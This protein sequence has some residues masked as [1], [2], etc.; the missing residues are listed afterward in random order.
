MNAR[1]ISAVA[2]CCSLAGFAVAIVAGAFAGGDTASVIGRAI[3]SMLV[4]YAVGTALAAV[5]SRVVV[6]HADTYQRANDEA[7]DEGRMSPRVEAQRT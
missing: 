6:E 2:P 7:H 3:V 1:P 5:A 4:M